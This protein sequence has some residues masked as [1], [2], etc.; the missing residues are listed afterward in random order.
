[1]TA[2]PPLVAMRPTA[3]KLLLLLAITT[4]LALAQLAFQPCAA[5]APQPVHP[6]NPLRVSFPSVGA[7]FDLRRLRDPAIN[8][9]PAERRGFYNILDTSFVTGVAA[10]N[11]SYIFNVSVRAVKILAASEPAR[12]WPA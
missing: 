10:A 4:A 11:Y 5:A 12:V 9:A 6:S 7:S 3:S 8:L 2:P 1:M